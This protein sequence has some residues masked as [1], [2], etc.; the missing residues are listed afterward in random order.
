MIT[1]QRIDLN[2]NIPALRKLDAMLIVRE[3]STI[4]KFYIYRHTHT[5]ICIVP[6][7]IVWRFSRLVTKCDDIKGYFFLALLKQG[8]LDNF[9]D[10]KEFWYVKRDADDGDK[11]NTQQRQDEKWW[12]P[13]PR[14]S[15]EGLSEVS[16]K[17]LRFQKESVSQVLK[18][19]MAINAQVL[20]EMEVPED[21]IESLP[22]VKTLSLSLPIYPSMLIH[23]YNILIHITYTH[24]HIYI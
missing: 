13:K 23:T 19:A 4:R 8:Y 21:Y 6:F 16:R 14:V 2:L 24:T 12:L 9:K 3:C 5:Q 17:W 18:L 15:P 20:S 10:Q 11:G 1:R 22:K 7:V